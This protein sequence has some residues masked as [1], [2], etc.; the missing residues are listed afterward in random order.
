MV[1]ILH[2]VIRVPVQIARKGQA[3]VVTTH[4]GL[5]PYGIEKL[6]LAVGTEQKGHVYMFRMEVSHVP[7]KGHEPLRCGCF[8]SG[9]G[10]PFQI[11]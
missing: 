6:T 10:V 7:R 2:S 8:S 11:P 5:L 3:C 4:G 1:N 9:P